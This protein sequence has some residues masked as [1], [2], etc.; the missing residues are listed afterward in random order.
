MLSFPFTLRCSKVWNPPWTIAIINKWC[1]CLHFHCVVW[2]DI[3]WE[4]TFPWC[5]SPPPLLTPFCLFMICSTLNNL[6]LVASSSI[7]TPPHSFTHYSSLWEVEEWSTMF[8]HLLSVWRRK[9]CCCSDQ[10]LIPNTFFKTTSTIN[11]LLSNKFNQP[12]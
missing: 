7:L 5:S 8:S 2:W 4:L 1:I 12:K 9:Y 3:L 6:K 10:T 11:V